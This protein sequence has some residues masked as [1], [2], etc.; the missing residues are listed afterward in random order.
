MRTGTM[1]NYKYVLDISTVFKTIPF[2]QICESSSQTL[3][4]LVEK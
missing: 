3:F 1:Q 2:E 4:L